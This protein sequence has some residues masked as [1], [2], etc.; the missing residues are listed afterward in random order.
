MNLDDVIASGDG[1]S[2]ATEFSDTQYDHAFPDGVEEHWWFL[3]RGRILSNAVR[4]FCGE[5]ASLLEVGCGRGVV[6]KNLRDGGMACTGVELAQVKPIAAVQSHVRCG[7]DATDLP[8]G[9]REG[10]DTLLLL[11][12]IEHLPDPVSFVQSLFQAF[13]NARRL[14]ITVPARQELWSNYD[15]F[16]GHFRR[17]SLPMTSEF[18]AELGWETVRNEYFFHSVYLPARLLTRLG[19]TRSTQFV[20]PRGLARW[21]HRL[22]AMSMRMD[23]A[24]VPGSWVGTSVLTCLQK[25]S[26]KNSIG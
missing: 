26:P 21:A 16:F 2:T 8:V 5:N 19:L 12:V 10:Y 7:I 6:V 14:V 22:I 20:A 9:E 25:P 1:P 15:E 4:A 3:A 11:D 18:G 17:Y 24:L 23:H 13:P